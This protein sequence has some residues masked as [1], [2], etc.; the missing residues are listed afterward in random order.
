MVS[1][2]V[3]EWLMY[4]VAAIAVIGIAIWAIMS[5][6]HKKVISTVTGGGTGGGSGGSGG[7]GNCQFPVTVN[8]PPECILAALQQS[9]YLSI[10]KSEGNPEYEE[11]INDPVS[12]LQNHPY[13][14]Q[15]YPQYFSC[16]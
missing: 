4:G 6:L 7:S 16:D 8:S 1:H 2:R 15:A 12:A 3:K 14:C 13:L 9:G 5:G 10:L 11:D